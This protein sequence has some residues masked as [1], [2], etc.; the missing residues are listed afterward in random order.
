MK[1]EITYYSAFFY[2]TLMHPDIL[3]RVIGNDGAHLKIC[4]AILLDH[5]RHHVKQ[6]DYPALLPYTKSMTMFNCKLSP[7]EKSVRGSLVTGLS[8]SDMRLLDIYEG[9][10]YIRDIVP[11][12]PLST[13]TILSPQINGHQSALPSAAPHTHSPSTLPPP[14]SAHVYIWCKPPTWL[15]PSLWSYEDF[16]KNNAWKYVGVGSADNADYM[17]VDRRRGMGGFIVRC[18]GGGQDRD[19]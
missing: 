18:G 5:T 10:E 6:A 7:E 14:I 9:D 3:K 16:V 2:G 19:Y 4:S 17:E 1:P 11:V 13:P 15:T 8:E 12:H